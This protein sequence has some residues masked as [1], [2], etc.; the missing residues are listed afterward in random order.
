M[1]P[2]TDRAAVVIGGINLDILVEHHGPLVAATSNPGRVTVGAGGVARN[3]AELLA[4]FGVPT[5]LIGAVGDAP[6]DRWLLAETKDAG[7]DTS[8]VRCITGGRVG[9]YVSILDGGNLATAVADLT[10]TEQL[11]WDAI[12]DALDAGPTDL[13]V[14]D[15]NLLPEVLAEVIR[16]ANRRA[17][18][19]V[20]EPVSVAKSAR[21]ASVS[22]WIDVI[23]PNEGEANAIGGIMHPELRIDHVLITRGEDG[24]RYCR[25]SFEEERFALPA[26]PEEPVNVNGA[27]DAF[28]AGVCTALMGRPG[29]ID[30]L[31]WRRVVITGLAAGTLAIRSRETTPRNLSREVLAE[32]V[33]HLAREIGNHTEQN[34]VTR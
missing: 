1:Q 8:G 14:V 23:T 34:G 20:V 22:G 9:T 17:V 6:I 19:V 33:E 12:R 31:D 4:R 25:G 7:V 13:V 10:T 28:V 15:C 32:M 2:V 29:G 16:W 30:D 24:A 26:I 3:I 18:P 11:G 5:R 21:L 27:G